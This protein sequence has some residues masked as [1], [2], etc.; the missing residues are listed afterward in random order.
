LAEGLLEALRDVVDVVGDAAQQ[1]AARL[2]VDVAEGEAVQLVLDL[3]AQT[4]HRSLHDPGQQE[5]LQPLEGGRHDVD[6]ERCEQHVAHVVEVDAAGAAELGHDALEQDVGGVAQHLGADDR[7]RHAD[8][9]EQEHGGHAGAFGGEAAHQA[10]GGAREVL[11]LLG[12][13]A[14][15]SAHAAARRLAGLAHDLGLHDGCVVGVVVGLVGH[16]AA[17]S[18]V[19]CDSTI[20]M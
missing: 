20:S 17:S 1:V 5:R 9:G 11:R 2:A 19:I 18:W 12:R 13:H 3:G 16:Q 10:A 8:D 14:R 4:Q 7:Q 15:H 6:A